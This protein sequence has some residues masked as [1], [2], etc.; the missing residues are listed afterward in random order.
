MSLTTGLYLD[1][2]SGCTPARIHDIDSAPSSTLE[3]AVSS[4][5]STVAADGADEAYEVDATAQATAAVVPD[6]G[7]DGIRAKGS[8]TTQIHRF[9]G[10]NGECDP[11]RFLASIT[12]T[13]VVRVRRNGRM[14]IS[15]QQE[16]AGDLR[17]FINRSGGGVLLAIQP[18]SARG[19]VTKRVR[20]GEY[21]VTVTYQLS[22]QTS[23][24]SSGQTVRRDLAF[25]A[26]IK[27][28]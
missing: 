11:G 22:Q 25:R 15:W 18:D 12:S 14:R 21:D 28:P 6:G 9:A 4:A 7:L 1:T 19:S 27:R 2:G 17:F 3:V 20:R 23:S 16:V 13:P 5:L 8:L 24:V 26:R 10:S